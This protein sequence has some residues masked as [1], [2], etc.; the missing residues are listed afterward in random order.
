VHLQFLSVWRAQER[1]LQIGNAEQM[2]L[3]GHTVYTK[4][5][6]AHGIDSAVKIK[7]DEVKGATIGDS[8][9]SAAVSHAATAAY[10]I[11]AAAHA[12]AVASYPSVET[13][14]RE[15]LITWARWVQL[16]ELAATQPRA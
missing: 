5:A 16:R 15:C 7:A 1:N 6:A 13:Q 14:S 3:S 2:K 9:K 10:S 4:E 8:I 12:C 11:A